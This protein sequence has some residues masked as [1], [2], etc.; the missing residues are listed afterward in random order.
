[1]TVHRAVVWFRPSEDW[2]ARLRLRSNR[3]DRAESRI[4]WASATQLDTRMNHGAGVYGVAREADRILD[5]GSAVYIPLSDGMQRA[6][7]QRW[8]VVRSST[9]TC[10]PKILDEAGHRN[11]I[12]VTR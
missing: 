2:E 11:N 5:F 10:A 12:Q 8:P 9:G 1:M 4:T 7:R 3:H 6:S